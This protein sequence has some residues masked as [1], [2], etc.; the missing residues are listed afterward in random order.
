MKNME[1]WSLSH[2]SFFATSIHIDAT[3]TQLSQT[4]NIHGFFGLLLSVH[5]CW[6]H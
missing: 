4:S 1:V 5:R 6:C 2:T 3:S